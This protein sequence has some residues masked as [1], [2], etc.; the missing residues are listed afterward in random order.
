M[1]ARAPLRIARVEQTTVRLNS[2]TDEI[3]IRQEGPH[4]EDDSVVVVPTAMLSTLI[5]HLRA[6]AL[7]GPTTPRQ[8]GTCE[9]CGIRKPYGSLRLTWDKHGG[10]DLGALGV[11]L[12]QV[13]CG[14]VTEQ[15]EA[16]VM[17]ESRPEVGE[18]EEN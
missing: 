3:E 12:C 13:C 14:P 15:W 10:E 1:P 4:G 7:E 9:R 5:G 11:E 8:K 6:A 2:E 18:D 16:L 17:T